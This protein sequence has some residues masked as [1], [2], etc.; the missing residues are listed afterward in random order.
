MHNS[1]R[2]LDLNLLVTLDALLAELNVTRAARRLNL[3]QSFNGLGQFVGP[4][5]GGAL[6]FGGANAGSDNSPLQTTY[7]VIAVIVLL[8]A[9]RIALGLTWRP[10][11]IFSVELG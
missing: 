10:G 1:L 7:V 8:V 11:E 5:L 2:R 9:V 6:F 4:L 3:A